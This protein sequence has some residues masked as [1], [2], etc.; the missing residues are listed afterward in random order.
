MDEFYIE[1]K[2]RQLKSSHSPRKKP[3]HH[4]RKTHR[5]PPIGIFDIEGRRKIRVL[6]GWG[7]PDQTFF[8]KPLEDRAGVKRTAFQ[9]WI[10]PNP[11]LQYQLLVVVLS[12]LGK[13]AEEI[14]ELLPS[15]VVPNGIYLEAE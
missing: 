10:S 1:S 14:F 11:E 12:F 7:E 15:S 8:P 3:G 4:H 6:G 5:D 13:L 9:L 2:T